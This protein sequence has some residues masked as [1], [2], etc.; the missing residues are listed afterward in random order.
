MQVRMKARKNGPSPGQ[1]VPDSG[2]PI[3]VPENSCVKSCA[4]SAGQSAA[5]HSFAQ[6]IPVG[7]AQGDE[8]R[9]R[10]ILV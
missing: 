5:A 10:L 2:P 6:G 7:L 4:W 1:R 9:A 8:R 3:P